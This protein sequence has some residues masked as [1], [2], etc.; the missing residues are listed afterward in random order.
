VVA[1]KSN[2]FMVEPSSGKPEVYVMA[3]QHVCMAQSLKSVLVIFC[4][5]R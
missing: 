4:Y 3:A 5:K 1:L 2:T